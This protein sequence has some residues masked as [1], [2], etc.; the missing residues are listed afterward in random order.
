MLKDAIELLT[1]TAIAAVEPIELESLATRNRTVAWVNGQRT[2]V[3]HD[4][5]CREHMICDLASLAT[6]VNGPVS[7]ADGELCAGR[8]HASVWHKGDKVVI[9]FDDSD[10]SYRDDGA[11]W[12]LNPSKKFMSLIAD[13]PKARNQAAFIEFLVE[14]LRD[15]LEASR[16]G[17]LGN[18]R[19]LRFKNNSEGTGNIQHNRASLGRQVEAEISGAIELPE[20]L[21]LNVR[22][23]ADMEYIVAVECYLKL[24][25]LQETL[26]LRPL[27]DELQEAENKAQEWLHE[28]ITQ[29]IECPVYYGTP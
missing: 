20:T 3:V 17:L 26:A 25:P 19:N 10:E 22:R 7:Q 5:P 1:K 28:R 6:L 9:V 4:V 29:E 12:T 2:E 24:D 8:P 15:E 11:E 16:P 23:W 14:N 21:I 18:L 13:A 27:A